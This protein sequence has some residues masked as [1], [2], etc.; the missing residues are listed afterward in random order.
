MFGCR[1]ILLKETSGSMQNVIFQVRGASHT[2]L[3][4]MDRMSQ[5]LE[6]VHSDL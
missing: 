4:Q 3:E 1:L 2:M 5:K 6:I